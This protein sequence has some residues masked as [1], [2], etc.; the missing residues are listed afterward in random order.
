MRKNAAGEYADP[1][2]RSYL[3]AHLTANVVQFQRPVTAGERSQM[4]RP[5]EEEDLPQ[6]PEKPTWMQV[7]EYRVAW[8]RRLMKTG[9]DPLRLQVLKQLHVYEEELKKGDKSG[10][11][12]DAALAE[13]V[14]QLFP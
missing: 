8:M 12:D 9:D 5:P 7:Q 3:T 1:E 14:R 13:R 2:V 10:G 4:P 11:L 6:L